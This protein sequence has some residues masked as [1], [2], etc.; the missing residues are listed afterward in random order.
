METTQ[1]QIV[2]RV[3]PSPTGFLHVGNLRTA[4]YSYFLARKHG[5]KFLIRI[6]DTDQERLVE[7]AVEGLIRMFTTMGLEYDGGPVMENG[8]LSEK[9]DKGP[10]TQSKRLP[11]YREHV[12]RLVDA[13]HAYHCFCSK[14]RLEEVR[15]QQQLAKLPTKYDRTCCTLSKDI[16]ETKLANGESHVIRMRIPEGKTTFIDEVRGSIVID[17]SEIDDQVLMKSDGFPTYHLAVVVD[18]HAMEVTHVIR[19]EEW[20]SSAPKHVI[21]YQWFGFALPAFAHLPLIL[22]PDKSKLSK[23]QGDV[24]VE[25]YL[26]KGYMTDALLNFI[27]LLGFNPTGD[28]ELYTKQELID[29]FELHKV[30]KSGAVLDVNKL[31]WMNSQYIKSTPDDVLVG[32]CKPFLTTTIDDAL[33]AKILHV[34]KERMERL[35]EIETRIQPYVSLQNYDASIL[36]WKKSDAADAKIQ[37]EQMHTLIS[38]MSDETLQSLELI[39]GAIKRYIEEKQLPNGNVLWPLRVSLSGSAQS[40]SPFELLWILGAPEA[41]NRLQHA[42]HHVAQ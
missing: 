24:A 14:E 38:S 26:K 13:G 36:V 12:Q 6:E 16:V 27:A 17:N 42:I 32:L 2:T 22:N 19:G 30:N 23:R 41:L 4:L 3:A 18:D 29:G 10:Y 35:D 39:E 28:R 25:D 31:N 15:T 8:Q 11:L 33:L 7:G 9:G 1:K 5:G 37:L 34:E 20:I 21:L 40:A